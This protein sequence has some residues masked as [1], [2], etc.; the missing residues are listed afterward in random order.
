MVGLES[1]Y[2][3]QPRV[4]QSGDLKQSAGVSGLCGANGKPH[5]KAP[6]SPK[7]VTSGK[8]SAR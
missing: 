6:L 7:I 8:D 2:G 3:R 1:P 5:Q 4:Y